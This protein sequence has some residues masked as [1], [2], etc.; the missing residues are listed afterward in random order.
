M[1][2]VWRMKSKGVS[3]ISWEKYARHRSTRHT[4]LLNQRDID[5]F[6]GYNWA[7]KLIHF[8]H[9]LWSASFST[10]TRPHP[11]PHPHTHTNTN[12]EPKKKTDQIRKKTTYSYSHEEDSDAYCTHA[13]RLVAWNNWIFCT[14]QGDF[15]A[16]KYN[17]NIQN[18]TLFSNS[19]A[20]CVLI[21]KLILY[22]VLLFTI[23]RLL[24]LLLFIC[25]TLSQNKAYFHFILIVRFFCV[26]KKALFFNS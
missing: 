19:F 12:Y 20:L 23:D 6:D 10:K 1:E 5:I 21:L 13:I 7:V 16:K 2:V 11:H 8:A 25:F 18:E 15:A 22:F 9:M 14:I 26:T 4:Y 3:D 17:S 24:L